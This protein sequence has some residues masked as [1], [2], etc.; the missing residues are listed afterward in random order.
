MT[1]LAT[2]CQLEMRSCFDPQ[3]GFDP[4]RLEWNLA[5][6]EEFLRALATRADSRLYVL[7][8]FSFQ[9]WAMGRSV[10]D[11]NAAGVRIPGPETQ[12]IGALARE[13][14][15]YVAGT[16]FETIPEFPGRHF[17]TGFV[18]APDGE[19]VLRYR[20][21][22]AVSAKT[23]PGDVYRRYVE[24]FGRES[25][26]P[27]IA[28]PLGRLGMVIA[29]DALWPETTRALALRGAEVILHPFGSPRTAS[30]ADTAFAHVRAV[31]AFENVACVVSANFGPLDSTTA[32]GPNGRWPSQVLDC[33]GRVLAQAD[34]D[35]EC[36][37]TAAIDLAAL[38]AQRRKPIRNFI[39]QLQSQLHAPDYANAELWPLSHW[40]DRPLQ[41]PRELVELEAEIWRR[42]VASGSFEGN[43]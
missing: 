15:A 8:E 20:K 3:G 38:R 11:W 21:L 40:E 6:T 30:D 32:D 13:L 42:L 2:A 24:L 16:L 36:G 1:Y 14:D 18:I 9:G 27:V 26:F 35:G 23:R 4:A 39:A 31:R 22:Y 33:E 29:W 41:H 28:T 5:H 12:R 7:P 19:L 37:V 43:P 34:T 17:L 10:E 25:L